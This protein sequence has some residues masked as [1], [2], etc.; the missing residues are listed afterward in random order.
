[1]KTKTTILVFILSLGIN[2]KAQNL[3]TNGY[4][5]IY[6]PC[7]TARSSPGNLQLNYATGWLTAASTPDY[8][9][10]CASIGTTVNVP[11]AHCGYQQDCCGGMGFA[12]G[13]ML[14]INSPNYD[15]EYIYT[16]LTDTLKV[17]HKY[18]ASM[19]VSRADGFD[20]AITTIG[21]L[22]TDTA[23]VL[24]YPQ[25]FIN[26]N[27]QVKNTTLLADTVN[28]LLVQDTISVG[29]N[30]TY[31]TIGDFNTNATCGGM[32]VGGNGTYSNFAYYYIDGVSVYDIT[33][34]ACNN[35][36]DAGY[37]KY[38]L[39]GDSVQL[40]AINTDNSIY[41]WVNSIGG[42]TYLSNNGNARPY[43]K[44][45]IT[46][47]YYVTKICPNNNVFQ[48]TVTVHVTNTAGLNKFANNLQVKVYPNPAT[49][50]VHIE[51]KG[52]T[53][54][55]LCDL[56]GNKILTTN[57]NEIDVSNINNGVYFIEVKTKG[58]ISI[59]KIIIQH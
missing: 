27:P 7:P 17:G 51:T 22:F 28:W 41:T 25:S 19:Y 58:S 3:V 56:L 14:D 6:S 2:T 49:N 34:S 55:T 52:I 1:M 13:I 29:G 57:E 16:K 35:Y 46:T 54:I 50:V 15:L 12:G 47:T 44:P 37:N 24:P 39:I 53:E 8:Y 30:E 9:N 42:N 59:Q 23:I 33:G 31:L 48:D 38:I 10:T 4:F 18:L 36:W 11:Y 32:L 20:Y 43:S 26:A 45:P 21:M 5:E 40:G